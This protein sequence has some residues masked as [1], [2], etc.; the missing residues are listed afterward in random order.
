MQLLVRFA[1]D[2]PDYAA[3]LRASTGEQFV[4]AVSRRWSTDPQRAGKVLSIYDEHQ[5]VFPLVS[6]KGPQTSDNTAPAA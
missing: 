4:Q 5:N 1:Q 3:A 6:A 2:Q